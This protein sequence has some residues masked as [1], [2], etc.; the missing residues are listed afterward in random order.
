MKSP[1][2]AQLQALLYLLVELQS[3]PDLWLPIR[4]PRELGSLQRRWDL[5]G[6]PRSGRL[7]Q[8]LQVLRWRIQPEEEV[9][10]SPRVFSFDVKHAWQV[11]CS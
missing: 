8:M 7:P 11:F 4:P 10:L 6:S 9:P 3:P 1:L 5:A 2:K